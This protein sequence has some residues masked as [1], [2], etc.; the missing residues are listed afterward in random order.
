MCNRMCN[1]YKPLNIIYLF[2]WLHM[3]TDKSEKKTI[4]LN[5]YPVFINLKVF[6]IGMDV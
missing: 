5:F 1:R 3:V 2:Y 6:K 4:L